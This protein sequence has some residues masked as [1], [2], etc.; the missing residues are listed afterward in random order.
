M[1][2][3]AD[4]FP[5]AEV[6]R[7]M[8]IAGSSCVVT[9][10]YYNRSGKIIPL[11]DTVINAGASKIIVVP[12]VNQNTRLRGTDICWSDLLSNENDFESNIGEGYRTSNIIFSSGTTGDPKAI[13]WSHLTPIKSAMDG[14]YHQDI[15]IPWW[16][17][18][19]WWASSVHG[20]SALL[21][22]NLHYR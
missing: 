18:D 22:S 10:D 5:A 4:S 20:P 11:Y 16:Y 19:R 2:S 21:T 8:S 1:V 15:R 7:R 3:I 6:R 14:H 12:S 9:L 13:P 17:R